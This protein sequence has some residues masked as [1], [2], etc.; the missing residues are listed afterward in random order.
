MN[1]WGGIDISKSGFMIEFFVDCPKGYVPSEEEV[2]RVR[3]LVVAYYIR[4][5]EE[6][7]L[8]GRLN[9]EGKSL[10]VRR[11]WAYCGCVIVGVEL[12]LLDLASGA[13]S[14]LALYP[15]IK[16]ATIEIAKDIRC[17]CVQFG[18]WARPFAVLFYLEDEVFYGNNGKIWFKEKGLGLSLVPVEVNASIEQKT[19]AIDLS[20]L[21]PGLES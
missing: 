4:L 17:L 14:V 16:R 10:V 21:E 6:A 19:T 18:D 13:V 11:S 9:L 8:E 7:V 3:A 12:E 15:D 20:P 2:E 5:L 1:E